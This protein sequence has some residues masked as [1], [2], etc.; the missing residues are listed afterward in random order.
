MHLRWIW[1]L[2]YVF[3]TSSMTKFSNLF[4]SNLR[5]T[6]WQRYHVRLYCQSMSVPSFETVLLALERRILSSLLPTIRS[7]LY[8]SPYR[9]LFSVLVLAPLPLDECLCQ[10]G[11]SE[12]I[13]TS[14]GVNWSFHWLVIPHIPSDHSVDVSAP[15]LYSN[16]FFSP[17]NSNALRNRDQN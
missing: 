1:R 7:A 17:L 16:L 4:S 15:V 3:P 11:A 13:Y 12:S 10:L 6:T 5:L 9:T 2:S 8:G 14:R